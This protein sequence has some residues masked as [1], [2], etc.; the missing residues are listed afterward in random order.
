MDKF[1]QNKRDD[2]NESIDVKELIKVLMKRSIY[3]K[4]ITKYTK[5][6]GRVE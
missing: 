2:I 5:F 4:L 6:T 3:N 1:Y